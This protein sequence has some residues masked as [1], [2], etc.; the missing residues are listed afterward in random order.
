[1]S[2]LLPKSALVPAIV[3]ACAW[4]GLVLT[5]CA[6]SQQKRI[7]ALTIDSYS[8]NSLRSQETSTLNEQLF[9]AAQMNVDPGDY[10]LGT[11]DLLQITVFECEELNAKARI[12]SRGYVTLPLLGQVELKG[13]SAREAEVLIENLYD[14]RYLKNPHV[15]VFVEEHFSQRITLMGQFKN[16]GTYDYFSKM[17]LI[18]VM[19]L[20]GGINDKA[21][22]IAQIRRM[23]A[24]A[25]E[26]SV[27]LVD[28]DKM[29][30]EGRSES[31]LEIN[32]GDVVFVP[33]AGMFFVD[34][35]VRKPGGYHITRQTSLSEAV[36]LAGGLAPYASGEKAI[37][38]R[39]LGEGERQVLELDMEDIEVQ[40]TP[41]NDR[42]VILI[43][44]NTASRLL[45]GSGLNIGFPGVF[46]FGYRDPVQ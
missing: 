33:E 32:A 31:N 42:D 5:G 27:L 19:A 20:G 41:V 22:R 26:P 21:G 38:V 24:S 17:R 39:H 2:R 35:A 30:R 29:L 9:S 28:I 16:P 12:S 8:V 7:D 11:G 44:T 6:T 46:S 37:L 15:S 18:D 45:Y 1:M 25:G 34:G 13:L 40:R 4:I 43:K 23:G 10:L 14:A 36:S 3:W